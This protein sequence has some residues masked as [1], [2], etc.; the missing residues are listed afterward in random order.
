MKK[1]LFVVLISLVFSLLLFAQQETEVH[2]V[3]TMMM[4]DDITLANMKR[5]VIEGAKTEAVKMAFGTTVTKD[6]V[7]QTTV[8]DGVERSDFV[9][10]AQEGVRGRWL[11][12][13]QP[14]QLSVNYD[15]ESLFFTAEVWGKAREI[16]QAQT[17]LVMDVLNRPVVS[18]KTTT[19][20][21]GD[22]IYIRFKAPSSGYLA[23]Y[24]LEAKQV[25]C[26]L[27]YKQM[28]QGIF[29]VEAGKE[30]ILFNPETDRNCLRPYRLTT[31][32]SV[33]T[34]E[35]V[36]VFSPHLFYKANDNKGGVNQVNSLDNVSFNEWLLKSQEQDSEMVVKPEII[37]IIRNN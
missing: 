5:K 20:N 26:L 34:N 29:A 23:V 22:N 25:S 3:V 14:T 19:F 2:G 32:M 1:R 16:V 9:E 30:Y 10:R 28:T 21:S 11:G 4:E 36:L 37:K 17:D 12:E 33:E 7:M 27:P 6:V 35:L 24:L 13:T 18:A 15:G 8:V 31:N